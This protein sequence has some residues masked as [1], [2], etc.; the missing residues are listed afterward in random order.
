MNESGGLGYRQGK[1]QVTTCS[2]C[3]LEVL[4]SYP[5]HVFHFDNNMIVIAL[6]GVLQAWYNERKNLEFTL[7]SV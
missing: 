3:D 5:L 1:T 7:F 2:L 6:Y 4:G